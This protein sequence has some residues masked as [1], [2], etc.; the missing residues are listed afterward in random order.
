VKK[1][2]AIKVIGMSIIAIVVLLLI[3]AILFPTGFGL[4][5][6][7]RTNYG[8]GRM[9]MGNGL[10]FGLSVSLLLTYL[11]KFFFAVFVIG[12]VGGLIIII[13]NNVFS[14]EDLEAFKAPFKWNESTIAK[15]TCRE[16]GKELNADWKSCP[17]CG[18]SVEMLEQ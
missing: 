17:H 6:N 7:V 13:K 4:G 14:S 11:I 18:T 8:V 10:G 9:Y 3:K 1:D 2:Y 5:I 15:V 16:C 12:L